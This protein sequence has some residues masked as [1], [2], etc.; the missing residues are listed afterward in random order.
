MV[1]DSKISKM[2]RRKLNDEYHISSLRRLD[3]T[4]CRIQAIEDHSFFEMSRLQILNLR[5][6]PE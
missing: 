5:Y 1:E 4:E 3:L 6:I 2:L